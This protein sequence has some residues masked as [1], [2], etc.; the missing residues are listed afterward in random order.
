MRRILERIKSDGYH[1]ED[2]GVSYW[3]MEPEEW[4]FDA[5]VVDN[6]GVRYRAAGRDGFDGELQVTYY[7]LR[8]L[9]EVL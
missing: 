6:N 4:D 3:E 8:D 5:N 1:V 7:A 9:L 2:L